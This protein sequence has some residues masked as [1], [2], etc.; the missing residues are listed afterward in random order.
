MTHFRD[1]PDRKFLIRRISNEVALARVVQKALLARRVLL[2]GMMEP[3]IQSA[4]NVSDSIREIVEFLEREI[5]TVTFELQVSRR[6]VSQSILDVLNAHK[7]L[8]VPSPNVRNTPELLL[9]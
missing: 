8:T 7:V 5:D 3:N 9:K 6:L 2:S 1:L 4:G